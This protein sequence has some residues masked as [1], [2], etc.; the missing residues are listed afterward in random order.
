[1]AVSPH[2]AAAM[3]AAGYTMT[4]E[5]P[6]SLAASASAVGVN[7]GGPTAANYFYTSYAMFPPPPHPATGTHAHAAWGAPGQFVA[8]H[9]PAAVQQFGMPQQIGGHG[10]VGP[11]VTGSVGQVGQVTPDHMDV[12]AYQFE[13][14]A[15]AFD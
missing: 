15:G 10:S 3:S 1:M 11:H 7:G 5:D 13:V 6:S 8:A 2:A 14:E 12:G 9:H 4:A